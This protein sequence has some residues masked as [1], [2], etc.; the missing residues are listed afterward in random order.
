MYKV[1]VGF[2]LS[3]IFTLITNQF[4]D[5]FGSY[6][7]LVAQHRKPQGNYNTYSINIRKVQ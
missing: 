4:I 6:T 3:D 5:W 1:I 2:G 7:K